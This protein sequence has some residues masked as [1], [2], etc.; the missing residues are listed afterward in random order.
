MTTAP[1]SEKSASDPRTAG[2]M[3][4]LMSKAFGRMTPDERTEMMQDAATLT[5]AEL[6][7][8]DNLM[9]VDSAH[10]GYIEDHWSTGKPQDIVSVDSAHGPGSSVPSG[11]VNIGPSQEAAGNGAARMEPQYSRYA[12]QSGLQTAT[13]KLG[14]DL[15]G[16]KGAMKS[17][18]KA[19]EGFG[20]QLEM[21]KAGTAPAAAPDAAALQ[22]MIEAAVAKAME[23]VKAD[24]Q[25][26][27]SKAWDK[28]DD[29]DDDKDDDE[30]AKSA[31]LLAK[32]DDKEKAKERDE[33]GDEKSA[34]AVAAAELRLMAKARITHARLRL[35]KALDYAAEEKAK[36]AQRA[37]T[38]ATINLAKA[39]AH[40]DESTAL[41]GGKVG[42]STQ[43]LALDIAKAKKGL[44][45]AET[46]NQDIW[47]ATTEAQDSFG[48]AKTDPPPAAETAK[49]PA[50]PNPDLAK[51]VAQI[52]A[53]ATGMGMMTASVA[54]LFKALSGQTKPVEATT[55][56]GERHNMPPVFALAKAGASDLAT[57]EAELA[58]LRDSNVISFED[59][60]HARD[61]LTRARMGLPEETI[62]AMIAR[63][64]EAAK[65]VLTRSAA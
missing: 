27:I 46:A 60:D 44:A 32:A 18:L 40:L 14:R 34:S 13:E 38:F 11:T 20:T 56:D 6:T 23:P 21:L 22:T 41:L 24:F 7:K 61:A 55:S 53:A 45:A 35:S 17:I 48:K 3:T 65:A 16:V 8:A 63:L 2:F 54:D 49:A 58:R 4:K 43:S 29:K 59:H 31:A 15:L 28:K 37:M 57:R 25:N 1:E 62:K 42:L 10:T 47:P 5:S 50:A 19:M 9:T 33:E 12:P 36:A 64:P 51:A 39:Q 52:E 30:E 26:I